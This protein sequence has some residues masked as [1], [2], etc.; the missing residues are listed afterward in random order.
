M[1]SS[2]PP[3]LFALASQS[4]LR[5]QAQAIKSLDSLPPMLLPPLLSEAIS[6]RSIQTVQAMV[7]AWPFSCLSLG[8]L[9]EPQQLDPDIFKAVLDGFGVLLDLEVRPPGCNLKV[10]DLWTKS[11]N[12][13]GNLHSPTQ[14]W[15]IGISIQKS[16][17]DQPRTRRRL[18]HATSPQDQQL[19]DMQ[20]DVDL[21]IK[22]A[23]PDPVLSFLIRRLHKGKVLPQICCRKLTFVG[24]TPKLP[25]LKRI[26]DNVHLHCVQEVKI[27]Y[28]LGL[29][30]LAALAPYMGQMVHVNT[31]Y[32]S[33]VLM[34]PSTFFIEQKVQKLF[35]GFIAQF[36]GMNQL[37]HLH[38]DDVS[39]LEGRV[40]QLLK[41]VGT[42]L[43]TLAFTDCSLS[44]ADLISLSLGRCYSRL[45]FLDLS[46]VIFIPEDLEGL[47]AVLLQASSTVVHLDLGG[48]CITDTQLTAMLPALSRCIQLQFLRLCGNP[49]SSVGLE[50]LLRVM[51]L[52]SKSRVLL[53]PIPM[54]CYWGVGGP[55]QQGHLQRYLAELRLL[56][57]EVA[58]PTLI[59]DTHNTFQYDMIMLCFEV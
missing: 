27:S 55:L 12:D 36:S 17:V 40:D 51:L 49:V 10:L 56:L 32:L 38:L 39:S 8:H 58:M 18:N 50:S 9:M 46:E 7:Q 13:T 41:Y 35:S 6:S 4:I 57:Q 52:P 20:L 54:D 14:P 5:N 47:R 30:D 34:D 2:S 11:P 59:Q 53:L 23:G 16:E 28:S 29:L 15:N 25:V 3:S 37:K 48:C 44:A 43:E 1:S 24:K 19:P 33:G 31:F 45:I 26:M 42:N 22:K 21:C